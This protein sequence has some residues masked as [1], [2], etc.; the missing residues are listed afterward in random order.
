MINTEKISVFLYGL[1]ILLIPYFSFFAEISGLPLGFMANVWVLL[2]VI[3]ILCKPIPVKD[4]SVLFILVF[5]AITILVLRTFIY[6]VDKDELLHI[7]H[8][9][10]IPLYYYIFKWL[11]NRNAID[12]NKIKNIIV[13][14]S[15]F[16]SI[17]GILSFLFFPNFIISVITKGKTIEEIQMSAIGNEAGLLMNSNVY[18]NFLVLGLIVFLSQK[19]W[20]KSTLKELIVIILLLFG[21]IVSQSRYAIGIALVFLVIYTVKKLSPIVIL[22]VALLML[23]VGSII[24]FPYIKKAFDRGYF[25]EDRLRKLE[26]ATTIFENNKPFSFVIGAPNEEIGKK[27]GYNLMDIFSDNS[28]LSVILYFGLFFAII[29]F[30]IVLFPFVVNMRNKIFCLFFIFYI[31]SIMFITN[32]I[33]WNYFFLYLYPIFWILNNKT[34]VQTSKVY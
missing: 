11:K 26:I 30:S 14:N 31:L 33:Y 22:T 20:N 21:I 25:L 15:I 4:L 27:Y 23:T 29:Y 12:F 16:Q 7:R 18:A 34:E 8:I 3:L 17:F 32:C 13:A 5:L 10:V 28:Y 9:V 2:I 19:Q 24:F 1:L 6:E